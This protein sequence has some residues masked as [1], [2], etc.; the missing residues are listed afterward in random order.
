M[1][2]IRKGEICVKCHSFTACEKIDLRGQERPVYSHLLYL[3][4]KSQKLIPFGETVAYPKDY[5]LLDAK[6]QA[7][8]CY[9][10]KSGRILS[11]EI[12]ANGEERIFH[13]YEKGGLFLEE[14]V[15]FGQKSSFCFRTAC[16]TEL[17]RI[18]KE[19]MECAIRQDPQL[20]FDIIETASAKYLSAMEQLRHGKN[21]NIAWKICD[22]LLSF[23]DYNGKQYGKRVYLREKISQQ[24]ISDLLGVNRITTVRTIKKLKDLGLIERVRGMYCIPDVKALTEYQKKIGRD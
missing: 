13:F 5:V 23:A 11:Y 3:P 8:Y 22:L 7:E 1:C 14:N 10:V 15:L 6:E 2:V 9:V 16:E 17:I 24:T 4:D 21:Y 20:A 12:Y 18:D 19:R